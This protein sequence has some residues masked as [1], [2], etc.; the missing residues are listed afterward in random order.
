MVEDST[1]DVDLFS[2]AL[3]RYPACMELTVASDGEEAMEF[4]NGC[5]HGGA[6]LPDLVL[7]DLN[8]PRKHGSQVLREMKEDR[9]LRLI[10]VI[11]FSTSN[12][13]ADVLNAYQIGAS[14][15]FVKPDSFEKLV[16]FVQ[17]CCEFWAFAEFP[18]LTVMNGATPSDG[19]RH[20]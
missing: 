18:P 17:S 7:L 11:V 14:G 1:D 20:S 2:M 3:R 10:P 13:P 8:L 4:L 12:A 9:R 15:Y 19:P 6:D 5:N 16:K